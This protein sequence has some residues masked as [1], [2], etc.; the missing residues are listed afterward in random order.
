MRAEHRLRAMAPAGLREEGAVMTET[1]TL[2]P[3]GHEPVCIF[4][5]EE[6]YR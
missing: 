2:C 6:T 3:A 5:W 1:G 4:I